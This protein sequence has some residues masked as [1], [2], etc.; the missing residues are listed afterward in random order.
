[1]NRTQDH[2]IPIS[3]G[4]KAHKNKVYACQSCNSFKSSLTFV[5]WKKLIEYKF[6]TPS[7]MSHK[8]SIE[9]KQ[10]LLSQVKFMIENYENAGENKLA[11]Y[12]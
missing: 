3:K 11:N 7:F 8:Y 10:K 12:K 6:Q 4:G 5:E 2:V 1:M 9:Q